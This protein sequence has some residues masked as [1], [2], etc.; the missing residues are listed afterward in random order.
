M[1]PETPRARSAHK[2]AV[3]SLQRTLLLGRWV[4]GDGARRKRTWRPD[5]P[6][7]SSEPRGLGGQEE[8]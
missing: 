1:C 5:H 3:G 2:R 8:A 4:Q 7:V 6:P